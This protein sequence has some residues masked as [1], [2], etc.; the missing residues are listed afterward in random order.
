M[1]ILLSTFGSRGDV[2]PLVAL[3]VQLQALGTETRVCVPPDD[4]FAELLDRAG[5]PLAPAFSSV[6]QWLQTNMSK[7]TP[8]GIAQL[9][10]DMMVAQFEAI[11]AA[12]EGCDAILATGIFPSMAAAQSVAES[13]GIRYVCATYCPIWLRSPHHPPHEFPGR[14]HPPEGQPGDGPRITFARSGLSANWSPGFSTLLEFAE[15]C[16]V[17]TRY[18]CRSGV[19][20][21]CATAVIEGTTEYREPPLEEPADGTVLLCTATPHT[22]LVLD[23]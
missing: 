17:P 3:A 13:R 22:D 5:V 10:A 19:C 8:N 6:R 16:D 1:R 11:S 18:S 2:Q 7:R 4:E 9:A 20:H 14:P 15:A 23:L 21:T 12:A